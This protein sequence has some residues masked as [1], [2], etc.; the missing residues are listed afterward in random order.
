MRKEY[1]STTFQKFHTYQRDFLE[2]KDSM[3]RSI[4]NKLK[5]L[6][7][8]KICILVASKWRSAGC[9][10]FTFVL[11]SIPVF[12]MNVHGLKNS[13]NWYKIF[14]SCWSI[15]LHRL[16]HAML[17]IAIHRKRI[18]LHFQ[19]DITKIKNHKPSIFFFHLVNLELWKLLP[20]FLEFELIK[21]FWG[22]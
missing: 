22:K 3:V 10:S 13:E 4:L 7:L 17:Q 21:S 8:K 6:L 18:L 16:F 20:R 19:K 1:R 14:G 12:R 11:F 9:S 15:A 5:A 2:R